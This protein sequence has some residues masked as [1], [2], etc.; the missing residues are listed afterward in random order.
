MNEQ[1]T[2]LKEGLHQYIERTE[3]E[4]GPEPYLD[5]LEKKYLM[6]KEKKA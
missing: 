4:T 6:G 2:A 1:T 5:Y 3:K